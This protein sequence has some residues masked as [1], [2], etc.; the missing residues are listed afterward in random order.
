M[1]REVIRVDDDADVPTVGR[2]VEHLDEER[3]LVEWPGIGVREEYLDDLSPWRPRAAPAAD[4]GLCPSCCGERR[5]V[6]GAVVHQRDGRA[7]CAR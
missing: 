2:I 6:A 7:E 1:T 5:L 4:A 3:D